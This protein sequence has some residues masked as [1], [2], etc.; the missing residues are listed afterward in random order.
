MSTTLAAPQT[1]A[2][3]WTFTG[4]YRP[5]RQPL[6]AGD[7]LI[8]FAGSSIYA[9]NLYTGQEISDPNGF[10]FFVE[11]ANPQDT[12]AVPIVSSNGA[13]FFPA[14][15]ENGNQVLRALRLAD[16]TPLPAD[17]WASPPLGALLSLTAVDELIL[18]VQQDANGDTTVS[19]VFA[20]DGTTAW[21]PLVV[22]ELT[23]GSVGYGDH[24]IFF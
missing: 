10:P 17:R 7:R 8:G 15:D 6:L 24:A 5:E 3:A 23:S 19:A 14:A 22:T 20:T 18:I 2:T 21:G 12:S 13:V 1:L 9:V 16:G 4:P 11:R